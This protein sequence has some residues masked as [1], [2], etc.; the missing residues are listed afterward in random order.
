MI[1]AAGMSSRMKKMPVGGDIPPELI[2]QARLLPKSMIGVGVDGRPFLEYLITEVA[3]AGIRE[4]LMVLNPM[5]TVTEPHIR[6]IQAEGRF[7]DLIFRF[8]IQYIAPER[9]KPSGTAD[10]VLQALEQMPDWQTER[11]LVCNADNLY[12]RKV[13]SLLASSPYQQVLPAYTFEALGLPEDRYRNLA[14]IK[15]D[16]E[17]YVT[18]LIE[19]PD[20]EAAQVYREAGFGVSMNAYALFA[21]TVLPFLRKVPYSP[22]RNEKELPVAIRLLIQTRPKAVQTILVAEPVPDLTGMEDLIAVREKLA[23]YNV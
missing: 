4:V 10:A 18:D 8:A 2:E 6:A 11:F 16:A 19:K 20:R 7:L 12:S 9:T 14:I 23:Q 3:A 1:M 15:T 13:L 22:M 17:G 21:P 5:D